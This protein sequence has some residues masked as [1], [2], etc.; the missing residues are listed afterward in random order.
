MSALIRELESDLKTYTEELETARN[1]LQSDPGNQTHIE[2]IS[3]YEEVVETLQ[4]QLAEAQAEA[5]A[6]V[7]KRPSPPPEKWSKAN[8]P[9][10][11]EEARKAAL[12]SPTDEVFSPPTWKVN[13][14]VQARWSG[15]KKFY[16]AKIISITGSSAAPK[17]MV[18]F[19]DYNETEAVSAQHIH[20]IESKKRKVDDV[21]ATE[22]NSTF[23]A[24]A[25]VISAAADIN[26][27]L[28][29]QVK[30]E[31]EHSKVSDGPPKHP[32]PP[33]KIKAPGQV[34]ARKSQWQDFQA[35]NKKGPGKQKES[36]FRLADT[37]NARGVLSLS[38]RKHLSDHTAVGFT[39]SGHA[40]RKDPARSRYKHEF[41]GEE[42]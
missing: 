37:P 12:Q 36:M 34:E 39:G 40:M 9:K 5:Q 17:Y 24:S 13:D 3:G 31:Q 16:R 38:T 25:G 35:K 15:D 2:L 21:P 42:E 1:R 29:S 27:E 6:L 10:F 8:H 4:T 22:T 32:R 33:K 11:Q 30:K 14:I 19:L 23:A 18:N 7:A 28:A 26:Q 20:P 41:T